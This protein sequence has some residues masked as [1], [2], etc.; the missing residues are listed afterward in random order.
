LS[1]FAV[2]Y[3]ERPY[4]DATPQAVCERL[5]EAYARLPISMVLLGWELPPAIEEAVAR[6]VSIHGGKLFRWQPL[7]TGDAHTILPLEWSTIGLNG[8]PILGYSGL[9]EFTF[10]CPNHA[11]VTEFLL[12]RLESIAYSG[13]YTGIFL[14]RI[15]FPSPSADPVNELAC[16]CK[17]CGRLAADAGLDLRTVRND[18]LSL[19]PTG[20][21]S[22]LFGR[23]QAPG[24]PMQAYLDFRSESITH[25]V[26]LFA[27]QA[28]SMQLEIGLDCFSPSLTRMVGQDLSALGVLAGWTKIMTYPR[29]F[30]PAGLPF[31]LHRLCQWLMKNGVKERQALQHIADVSNLPLPKSMGELKC[32]GLSSKAISDEIINGYTQGL[33]TLLAG[34]ALVNMPGVH[35]PS[36][37]QILSDLDAGHASN[38]LVISWDLWLTPLEYLDKIRELWS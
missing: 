20:I 33:K 27:D 5:R 35:S 36:P 31:E 24:S 1:I 9:P 23:L 10:I 13:L 3:L 22:G 2:Q 7:L 16:F 30:G 18:I 12:E 21:I 25:T 6:E 32:S 26:R 15:R 37:S 8:Q 4:P 29:V 14:D 19:C 11:A 34:V 38:G 17:D 28:R